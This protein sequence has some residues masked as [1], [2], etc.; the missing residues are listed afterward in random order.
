MDLKTYL[1]GFVVCTLVG[2]AKAGFAGG[3]GVLATP[4]FCL[5]VDPR[6]AVGVLLPVL[7]AADLF[8]MYYYRRLFAGRPLAYALVGACGG[9]VLGAF[10]LGTLQERHL[11]VFVG[12]IALLFVFYRVGRALAGRASSSWRPGLPTGVL[13]GLVAGFCST[14]AHAG[15]PIMAA[16]L[17][18]QGL[19]RRVYVGTTV[20]FFGIVNHLKLIPYG[21]LGMLQGP[22]LLFSLSLLPT[23]P[24]GVWLGVTLNKKISESAFLVA[25]YIILFLVGLKLVGVPSPIELFLAP[26][27]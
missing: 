27:R 5:A 26:S 9:I 24:L 8:S 11:K 4:L 16:Y 17:L 25:V 1:V 7:C 2:I 10:F 14:M 22:N 15:G 18:P 12:A 19:G 13:F 21:S 3:I 20:F 23:V 6:K